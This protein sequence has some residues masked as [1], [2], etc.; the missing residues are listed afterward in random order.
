M[1]KL[2]ENSNSSS[3]NINSAVVDAAI[4]FVA[5]A[6]AEETLNAGEWCWSAVSQTIH[7]FDSH[8]L[9]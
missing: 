6:S 2:N 8:T 9:V 7:A 4:D 3:C 5:T 1:Q